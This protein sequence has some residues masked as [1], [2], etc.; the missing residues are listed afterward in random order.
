MYRMMAV[1]LFIMIFSSPCFARGHKGYCGH[2]TYVIRDQN[3]RVRGYVRNGVI[4]D[5]NYRTK[6]YLTGN[7]IRNK[8]FEVKG[9][10]EPNNRGRFFDSKPKFFGEK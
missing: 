4:R 10:V 2:R 6:G 7:E 9:Y 1:F 3:Y 5:K 8:N